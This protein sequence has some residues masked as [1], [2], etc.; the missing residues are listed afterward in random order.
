MDNSRSDR[1]L[2]ASLH[3]NSSCF[4]ISKRE[5][6]FMKLIFRLDKHCTC[7]VYS[8]DDLSRVTENNIFLL[9]R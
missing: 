3:Q 9:I 1:Q 4:F 8:L 7:D 6:I 5:A 2:V